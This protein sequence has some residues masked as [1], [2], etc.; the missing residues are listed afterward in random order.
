MRLIEVSGLSKFYKQHFWSTRKKVLNDVSF[1]VE[2]G[3]IFGFLGP[4]GSGKSTTIKILLEIIFPSSGSAKLLEKPLGDR[5]V[6]RQ[7]GFLPENPYF[8]DYLTA[9]Q[10]LRFHGHLQ[11]MS[12][13]QLSKRIPEVLDVVGMRGTAKYRLRS[14]SKGMLQRVGLAQAI[15]HDPKLVILDE[16]MTGLDPIGR[17]EVR[18][19]MIDLRQQGKTVFFSTHILSDVE[20]ICDRVAILNKGNLL[21]CGRLDE[22]VSVES[23]YVDLVWDR[24]PQQWEKWLQEFHAEYIS[25]GDGLYC[26]LIPAAEEAAPQFE[27]RLQKMIASGLSQGGRLHSVSRKSETLEDLFVRQVGHL[28]SRV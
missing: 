23:K 6:K 3:E 8:Y 16:P 5:G 21:S 26:K 4:N 27:D 13:R 24:S 22:L 9:E 12:G 7:I 2:A 19:I 1:H 14:F 17:K 25:Q 28:E 18:D 15:L 10:F 20:S 11:Q